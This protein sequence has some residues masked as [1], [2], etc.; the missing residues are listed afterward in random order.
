MIVGIRR[1]YTGSARPS[2]RPS[3]G[4]VYVVI[5][6]FLTIGS[7]SGTYAQ[8][9]DCAAPSG[10][11]AQIICGDADLIALDLDIGDAFRDL[12]R[13]TPRANRPAVLRSQR[14]WLIQRNSCLGAGNVNQCLRAEIEYRLTDLSEGLATSVGADQPFGR[15]GPA[16]EP[17][18]VPQ[19]PREIIDTVEL[20]DSAGPAQNGDAPTAPTPSPVPPRIGGTP[21]LAVPPLVDAPTADG[22]SGEGAPGQ[23][24]AVR[25]PQILPRPGDAGTAPPVS[26]AP[27]NDA[28]AQEIAGFLSANIWRA[29]IASG[30]RPGTIYIFHANGQW[31]TADCVEAYRIGS[32][33]IEGDGLRLE[34]GSG[35]E[36]TAKIVDRGKGYVR[37]KFTERQ[38]NR[39]LDLVFRPAR[40]PFACTG[41]R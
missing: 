22:A 14:D 16:T 23:A 37:L 28:D 20:P 30:I 13:S 3:A 18:A 2:S 40:G 9:V 21:P 39:V 10:P 5:S 8:T 1:R 34:D 17:A 26:P 6:A 27:E 32:W 24:G 12:I 38:G 4:F 41:A 35:R 15:A 33:R 11:V 19:G 36:L 7:A 25:R 29:E 31:L